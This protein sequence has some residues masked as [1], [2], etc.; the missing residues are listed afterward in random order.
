MADNLVIFGHTYNGVNGFKAKDTNNN[1]ITYTPGGSAPVLETLNLSYTPSETAISDT[2]T[3]S[4]GYDGFDEV[5]VSVSAI[6]SSYVGSGVTRQ[7]AQTIHPSTNDQ[8]IAASQYLTGAQTIKG[9]LLTNLSAENIKKDVVVKIGDSAD[10]DCVTS[11]T[12]TYEGSGSSALYPLVNGTKTFS[13]GT[14]VTITN[15]CHV[16][17]TIAAGNSSQGF[18]DLSDISENSNN[19][20]TADNVKN[21][22]AKF[23]ISANQT[24]IYMIYNLTAPNTSDYNV[25]GTGTSNLGMAIASLQPSVGFGWANKKFTSA[26]N[27]GCLFFCSTTPGNYSFDVGFYVNGVKY[28]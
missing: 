14:T 21:H 12:G 13:N 26:S 20:N 7:S 28:V 16:E 18:I 23:S 11:V 27:V 24:A 4:T 6:S 1:E 2:Q 17:I 10:D 8:S 5:N 3:P 25:Y 15:G 9:V 22:S 19:F